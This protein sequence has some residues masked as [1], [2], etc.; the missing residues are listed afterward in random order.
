MRKTLATAGVLLFSLAPVWGNEPGRTSAGPFR[1]EFGEIDLAPNPSY[2]QNTWVSG[3]LTIKLTNVSSAPVRFAVMMN[4]PELHLKGQ[5]VSLPL[6]TN[7]V[8]GVFPYE[9]NSV[10][11]C[12]RHAANFESVPPNE[13]RGLTL[14]FEGDLKGKEM[15]GLRAADLAGRLIVQFPA[16]GS[17]RS[18]SFFGTAIPARMR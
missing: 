1:V 8:R 5:G 4:W 6:A 9:S 18:V 17:C 14:K 15:A 11:E 2:A 10:G 16:D 7:G 13:T 12:A 3:F